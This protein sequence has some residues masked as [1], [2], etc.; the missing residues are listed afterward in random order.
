MSFANS[1]AFLESKIMSDS[2]SFCVL[3]SKVKADKVLVIIPAF[4]Q[5]N[6]LMGIDNKIVKDKSPVVP[7]HE[8][9]LQ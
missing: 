3:E 9:T 7:F 1:C 4:D 8:I 6:F 5:G 2:I